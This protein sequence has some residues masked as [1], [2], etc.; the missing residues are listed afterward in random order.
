MQG[1]KEKWKIIF[2]EERFSLLQPREAHQQV[3]D[4]LQ[5]ERKENETFFSGITI[6]SQRE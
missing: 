6:H 1:R 3:S 4:Y 2:R 5:Q